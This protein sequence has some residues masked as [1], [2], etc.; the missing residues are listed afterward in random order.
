MFQGQASLV[1]LFYGTGDHLV[2][3]SSKATQRAL[4]RK[5]T[6]KIAIHASTDSISLDIAV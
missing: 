1:V 4:I 2:Q 5:P 6:K 3:L